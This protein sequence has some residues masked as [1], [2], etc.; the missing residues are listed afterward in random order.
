LGGLDQAVLVAPDGQTEQISRLLTDR[1]EAGLRLGSGQEGR[2]LPGYML[3]LD[4]MILASTGD[5]V[6]NELRGVEAMS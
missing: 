4:A 2:V 3:D 6:R 5:A 1:C